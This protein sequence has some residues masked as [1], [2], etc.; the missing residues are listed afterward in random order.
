MAHNYDRWDQKTGAPAFLRPTADVRGQGVTEG[1]DVS[2]GREE[3]WSG[4]IADELVADSH[5]AA[6]TVRMAKYHADCSSPGE[7]RR[8]FVDNVKEAI[9]LTDKTLQGRTCVRKKLLTK[10]FVVSIIAQPLFQKLCFVIF[11]SRLDS[12]S[13]QTPQVRSIFE[14]L[15]GG[16]PCCRRC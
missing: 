10:F 6:P 12:G 5:V 8:Q 3:P 1:H 16:R 11:G 4:E 7:H 15:W 2:G 13:R 9:G 14:S